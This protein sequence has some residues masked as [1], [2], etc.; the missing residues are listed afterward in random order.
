MGNPTLQTHC[1]ALTGCSLIPNGGVQYPGL[2]EPGYYVLYTFSRNAQG[3]ALLPTTV[4][5]D[6]NIKAYA[7]R[8]GR[9]GPVTVFVLNKDL[10]FL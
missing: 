1:E 10:R 7:V 5:S 9:T 2:A 3:K 8:E 4:R 6:A